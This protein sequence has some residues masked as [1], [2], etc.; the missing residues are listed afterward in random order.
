VQVQ[1]DERGG[2]AGGLEQAAS[3]GGVVGGHKA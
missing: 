3:L 1:V 2:H